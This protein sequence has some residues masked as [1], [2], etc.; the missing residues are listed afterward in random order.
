MNVSKVYLGLIIMLSLFCITGCNK[1]S[2][3]DVKSGNTSDKEIIKTA[4]TGDAVNIKTTLSSG[5]VVDAVQVI[6]GNVKFDAMPIIRAEH[7]EFNADVFQNYFMK[8]KEIKNID[9]G[10]DKETGGVYKNIR[11]IDDSWL[12]AQ[13]NSISYFSQVFRKVD[14]IIQNN[15]LP[16]DKP[17]EKLDF[18]F[19]TREQAYEK[20]KSVFSDLGIQVYEDYEC[21]SLPFEWMKEE[22]E[23][24]QNQL[25]AAYKEK[26][27]EVQDDIEINWSEEM[28]C[29]YFVFR[30][31]VEAF[32]VTDKPRDYDNVYINA[33]TITVYYAKNGI[34][35]FGISYTYDG[36]VERK[37]PIINEKE[38]LEKLDQYYNSIILD[39][40]YLVSK[41]ELEY[42]PI[43]DKGDS[44][45][46]T[47]AWRFYID[48]TFNDPDKLEPGKYKKF[49]QQEQVLINAV[50]GKQLL[51]G[52]SDI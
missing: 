25:S 5:I 16:E 35:S 49:T 48:H 13:K 17:G 29:Y 40:D 34:E 52:G 14:S 46:L 27:S 37:E 51:S 50:D 9:Q 44:Y 15:F 33:P 24:Y 7:Q 45:L 2:P 11:T 43:P 23:A 19:A 32:P 10:E 31:T 8:D 26:L 20:I 4:V 36:T 47:P 6:P 21:Y 38:A 18:E 12:Y 39:G 1:K 41:I 42:V 22:Y 28:N 3:E 30:Q